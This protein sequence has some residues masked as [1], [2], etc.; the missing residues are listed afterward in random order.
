[1]CSRRFRRNDLAIYIKSLSGWVV[2]M[3]VAVF[4]MY[5][6]T[7]LTRDGIDI[8]PLAIIGSGTSRNQP[9]ILRG[10]TNFCRGF[11]DQ[12]LG[13]EVRRSR[14]GRTCSVA[15]HTP[16]TVRSVRGRCANAW[17]GPAHDDIGCADYN[18]ATFTCYHKIN[19][20]IA[21]DG[22]AK[23]NACRFSAKTGRDEARIESR[24]GA[25]LRV[26]AGSDPS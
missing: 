5:E 3:K 17:N 22:G 8:A 15:T 14:H 16:K 18:F 11:S 6:Y 24:C 2:Y 19:D 21:Y 23:V 4:G 13:I 25:K 9:G 10:F 12:L 26:S 7:L 1:M 20:K